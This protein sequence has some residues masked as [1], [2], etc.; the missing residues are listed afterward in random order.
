MRPQ[1]DT[2]STI[3]SVPALVCQ[4][5]RTI[6]I[7]F[8]TGL[9][10]KTGKTY[11]NANN[12]YFDGGNINDSLQQFTDNLTNGYTISTNISYTEPVGKKDS[13]SSA[14]FLLSVRANRTRRPINSI[15]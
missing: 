13:F 12:K 14:M 9:N 1:Q 5:R 6:S 4:K 10:Q 2:I 15:M 8:N 3:I 7:G 11:L